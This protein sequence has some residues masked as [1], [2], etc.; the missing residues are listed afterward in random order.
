MN[1]KSKNVKWQDR[2][3]IKSKTQYWY[4]EIDI[5]SNNKKAFYLKINGVEY[6]IP[7]DIFRYT[8]WVWNHHKWI[9]DYIFDLSKIGI[10]NDTKVVQPTPES[11]IVNTLTKITEYIQINTKN[12]SIIENFLNSIKQ[13]VDGLM[14]ISEVKKED[15]T[16]M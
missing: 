2:E 16:I 6:T 12:N 8:I 11:L 13:S 1:M 14:K 7:K 15:I 10:F 4:Y 3:Y 5:T 9:S